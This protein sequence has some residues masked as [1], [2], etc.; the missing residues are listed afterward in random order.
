MDNIYVT[1]WVVRVWG[2]DNELAPRSYIHTA[3]L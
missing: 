2:C 1:V 3:A